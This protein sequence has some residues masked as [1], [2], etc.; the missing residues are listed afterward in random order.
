[1]KYNYG[2]LIITYN[3]YD[4]NRE[5]EDISMYIVGAVRQLQISLR[6]KWRLP[7]ICYTTACIKKS[8]IKR[9]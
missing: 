3:Y 5:Q 7:L 9:I 1:M 8:T 4:Y 6:D 2:E